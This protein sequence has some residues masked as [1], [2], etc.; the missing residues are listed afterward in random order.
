MNRHEYIA[1]LKD[2]LGTLDQRIA[3]LQ[4]DVSEARVEGKESYKSFF[5]D[6]KSKREHVNVKMHQVTGAT[7]AAW[8]EVKSGVDGAWKELHAAYDRAKAEIAKMRDKTPV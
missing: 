5:D 2:S 7:D 6:L 3:E 1:K 4:S 8:T